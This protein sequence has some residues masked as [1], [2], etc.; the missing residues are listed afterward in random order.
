[1]QTYVQAICGAMLKKWSPFHNRNDLMMSY[2]IHYLYFLQI[3]RY[4][5]K[6]SS[7]YINQI[8]MLCEFFK[9]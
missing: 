8:I 3:I 9:S 2:W 4:A 6:Y 1:M 5:V 7:I